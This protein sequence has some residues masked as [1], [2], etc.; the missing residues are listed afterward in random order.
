MWMKWFDD[1]KDIIQKIGLPRLIIII[2][3]GV[4]LIAAS[5]L[6]KSGDN[7]TP[8]IETRA[9]DTEISDAV[10]IMYKY[11]KKNERVLEEFLEKVD[12]IGEVEVMI[13]L[14]ASEKKETLQDT[15]E[16]SDEGKYSHSEE[17]VIISADEGESP[18]VVQ[19]NSPQ[20]EGVVV[21]AKGAGTGEKDSEIIDA[22]MALFSVEPHKIK[23]MKLK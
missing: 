21:A 20:I 4:V 9:T 10:D 2:L 18:Y 13:T 22:V 17:N 16:N 15:S 11:T 12:G 5:A 23:V 3:A 19:V 14:K 6:E 8:V 7:K 1:K